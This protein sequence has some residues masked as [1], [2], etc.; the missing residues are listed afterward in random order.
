M[1]ARFA[2]RVLLIEHRLPMLSSRRRG[3]MAQNSCKI[4]NQTFNSQRELQEHQNS[5]HPQE[6]RGQ[7]EPV[8]DRSREDES[9]KIA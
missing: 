2:S 3:L 7:Q 1:F 8:G 6:S 4:C 5:S 9:R